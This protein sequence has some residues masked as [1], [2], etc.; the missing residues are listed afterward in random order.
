MPISYFIPLTKADEAR[1]EVWGIAAVE[2]P[3]VH[4][5]ILDYQLS[6][7]NFLAWSERMSQVTNGKSKG[8]I[9][10]MHKGAFAAVG[11][12]I[13]FEALDD[14]KAFFVGAKI[15]DDEAW[16]KVQEGV[17]TGFSVGGSYGKRFPDALLKGYTRYEALPSELSLVDVPAAPNARF[18]LVK[19]DGVS[20]T[21]PFSALA[22]GESLDDLVM[23]VRG[24]WYDRFGGN[25]P[26]MYCSVTEVQTD[27]I[28]VDKGDAGLFAYPYSQDES[29]AITFGDP[30]PV[31]KQYVLKKGANMDKLQEII[32]QMESSDS[33]DVKAL[34]AQLKTALSEAPAGIAEEGDAAGEST[35]PVGEKS[36]TGQA[37]NEDETNPVGAKSEAGEA[38]EGQGMSADAV[39]EI[40]VN[41]LVELGLVQKQDEMAKAAGSFLPAEINNLRKELTVIE[42]AM[43]EQVFPAL[44][45][46]GSLDD[47]QKSFGEFQTQTSSIVADLAKVAAGAEQLHTRLEALEKRGASGPVLREVPMLPGD[48]QALETLKKMAAETADAGLRQKLQAEITR[49][50]IKAA[51][52]T[53]IS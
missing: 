8:N 42:N 38:P 3:D 31:E 52:N 47:L 7:P 41:L 36:P 45:S 48:Q 24:A 9:R 4:R 15:V 46:F 5:E 27:Q 39:K 17:Y 35:P 13:H 32:S 34:A 12:V 43:A 20:E 6:K 10:A 28:I 22:K 19:M 21:R 33:P 40:V 44:K 18:E 25:G 11:K 49:L 53:P 16:A 50:G 26:E 37:E 29:G 30:S 14:K 2:E 23:K 1:R 51:Q